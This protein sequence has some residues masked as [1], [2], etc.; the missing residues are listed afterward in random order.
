MR[1]FASRS[2]RSAEALPV[3]A[4]RFATLGTGLS[5]PLAFKSTSLLRT[6]PYKG[7]TTAMS[8]S[9]GLALFTYP[10]EEGET[11]GVFTVRV[12]HVSHVTRGD[13][14]YDPAADTAR[15]ASFS[16]SRP[17]EQRTPPSPRREA[18]GSR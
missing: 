9:D 6:A 15:S 14:M 4:S 13:V 3:G 8:G 12:V 17:G 5:L 10:L 7:R 2:A 11:D 16:V 1:C 18:K